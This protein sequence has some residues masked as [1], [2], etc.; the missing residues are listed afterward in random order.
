MKKR[1][2]KVGVD[3]ATPRDKPYKIWDSI[4]PGLV[5]RVQPTGRRSWVVVKDRN[6]TRTIGTYPAIT[7]E[8]AR[9]KAR[10]ILSGED[11]VKAA[12]VPTLNQFI[13]Q[14]YRE[15]LQ[16]HVT[17]HR[18]QESMI[19]RIGMGKRQLD[20]IKLADIERFRT[21]RLKAGTAATT[22][23]RQVGALKAALQKALD[24]EL[25][26][27]HPLARLKPLKVDKRGVVRYLDTQ[28][29]QRL[30][31]T[32]EDANP[33][34]RALV[35]VALNTGLRRGELLALQWS[36]IDF[37]RRML[38]VHGSGAK[39]GQTRHVPLNSTAVDALKRWRGDIVPMKTLPVFGQR[40]FK[41]AWA[42]VLKRAGIEDFRFHDCRHTFASNLVSAGVPLNT[43]RE[44]LGHAKAEM[45]LIY[46]HLAPDTMKSAVE[47]IG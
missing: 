23:N 33:W 26:E 45:T 37:K 1:L 32:L 44:L 12:T 20:Q 8:M 40:E 47:L 10:Q 3:R 19:A 29:T 13:D 16:A 6:S 31:H 41:K 42:S 27:T 21:R 4:M 11:E 18:E 35:T 39:S 25:I 36:D 14:Y 38:V 24:W 9:E 17:R 46:A 22:L 15:H 30:L 43:V 2:T 5:L 34:L 28:E 7:V